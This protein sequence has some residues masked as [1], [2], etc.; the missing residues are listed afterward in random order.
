MSKLIVETKTGTVQGAEKPQ[1]LAFLGIPYAKAGRF[2]RPQP[3][4]WKGVLPCT[5]YGSKSIATNFFRNIPAGV[6]YPI[7]GSED[8]LNLNIWTPKDIAEGEKLP[9]VFYVHG[10]GYQIG[11]NSSWGKVEHIKVHEDSGRVEEIERLQNETNNK[12]LVKE[13]ENIEIEMD[14]FSDFYNAE[15]E[16]YDNSGSLIN[17]TG[18]NTSMYAEGFLEGHEILFVCLYNCDMNPN[19]DPCTNYKYLF[20]KSPKAYYFFNQCAQ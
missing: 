14:A 10:G 15:K 8:C 12:K 20:E 5:A 11:S 1:C 2:E 7:F 17:P 19:E 18:K 9:V 16:Q 13:L 4:S 3:Y 6:E